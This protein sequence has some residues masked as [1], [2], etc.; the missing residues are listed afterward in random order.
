MKNFIIAIGIVV[1]VCIVGLF[2]LNVTPFKQ[3]L[4]DLQPTPAVQISAVY[5]AKLPCA[6]CSQINATLTMSTDNTYKETDEYVGRNV[7]F[8]ETGIWEQ[9]TGTPKDPNVTV[10]EFAPSG[11]GT[12]RDYVI[13]ANKIL[14]LDSNGE[15]ISSPFDL[16]YTK[17]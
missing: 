4:S 1:V 9:K 12:V 3:T 5:T 11:N 2:I 8:T 15:P 7:T 14:P 10:Y 16:S 17:K 13:E 6:D